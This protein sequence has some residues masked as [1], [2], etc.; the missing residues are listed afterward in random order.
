MSDHPDLLQGFALSRS[1]FARAPL[2]FEEGSCC[3]PEFKLRDYL[4][5]SFSYPC[6]AHFL[7]ES[8]GE[9]TNLRISAHAHGVR[10]HQLPADPDSSGAGQK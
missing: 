5:L 7:E 8:A 1:R 9:F 3:S 6:I 2:L 10:W 4:F